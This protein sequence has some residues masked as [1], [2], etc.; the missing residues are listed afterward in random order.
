MITSFIMGEI[1]AEALQQTHS[2]PGVK[3]QLTAYLA[4]GGALEHAQEWR[5]MKA[6]ARPSSTTGPRSG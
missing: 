2:A 6:R 3:Q 1:P 5:R 4:N